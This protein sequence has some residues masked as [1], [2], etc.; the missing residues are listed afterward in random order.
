MHLKCFHRYWQ[1]SQLLGG[2]YCSITPQALAEYEKGLE[3]G[4]KYF[5]SSTTLLGESPP[6]ISMSSLMSAVVS[7]RVHLA[8]RREPYEERFNASKRNRATSQQQG[9]D[10]SCFLYGTEKMSSL[11]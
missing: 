3:S 9:I 5:S 8:T 10:N 7:V 2:V 1:V 11:T 4:Q 6:C